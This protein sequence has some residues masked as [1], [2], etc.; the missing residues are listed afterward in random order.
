MKRIKVLY[1]VLLV[2]LFVIG[3][4]ISYLQVQPCALCDGKPYHGLC[5]VDRQ[6]GQVYEFTIY[7][8]DPFRPGELSDLQTVGTFSFLDMGELTGIQSTA[9]HTAEVSIPDEPWL[10]WSRGFCFG[11]KRLLGEHTDG[12]YL[13]ADLY[14]PDVPELFSIADGAV[15]ESRCYEVTVM[16]DPEK[17]ELDI[18][19]TGHLD[20]TGYATSHT[21]LPN[22]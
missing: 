22:I 18:L 10:G 6:A 19:V 16:N 8:T 4:W 13:I 11:C 5:L 21:G 20:L 15:Y 17:E 3:C 2:I 7:D 1:I 14:N 9:A 12:R